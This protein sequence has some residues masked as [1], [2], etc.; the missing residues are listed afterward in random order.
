MVLL[1]PPA[2]CQWPCH[3]VAA[4]HREGPLPQR[5]CG[6][7]STALDHLNTSAPIS[8]AITASSLRDE[9]GAGVQR[10]MAK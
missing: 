10:R 5:Q 4:E 2:R 9:P 3:A 7:A 8:R 6:Q 1:R